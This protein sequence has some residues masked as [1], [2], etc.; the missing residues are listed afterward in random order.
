MGANEVDVCGICHCQ[1]EHCRVI[2]SRDYNAA[3]N[4]RRNLLFC[5]E[6]GHWDPR[7][8]KKKEEDASQ[9]QQTSLDTTAT[10]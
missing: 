5:I 1:N 6:N 9:Q 4:I 8:S 3:I 2:M 7:F 10:T